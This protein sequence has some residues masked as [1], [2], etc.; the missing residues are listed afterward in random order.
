MRVPVWDQIACEN[1]LLVRN[2]MVHA[3]QVEIVRYVF[4]RIDVGL[5]RTVGTADAAAICGEILQRAPGIGIEVQQLI[6]GHRRGA[7]V[8][9]DGRNRASGA[10]RV[11]ALDKIVASVGI[12]KRD[13]CGNILVVAVLL[14]IE[15]EEGLLLKNGAADR[16]AIF[17]A[18]QLRPTLAWR[19]KVTIRVEDVAAVQL[20]GAAMK[21]VRS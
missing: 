7:R 14:E 3:P 1:G 9:N 2:I 5:F 15:E 4:E 13:R 21:I 18:D 8:R 11:K 6:A 20:V 16:S 10:G 19:S 17:V 12:G